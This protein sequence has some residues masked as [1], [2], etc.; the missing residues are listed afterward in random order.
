MYF[1]IFNQT[2]NGIS[3]HNIRNMFQTLSNNRLHALEPVIGNN[4]MLIATILVETSWILRLHS[5]L[6]N[7]VYIYMYARNTMYV[8][9]V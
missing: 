2:I 1:C 9:C 4:Y 6:Y 3:F 7:A 8:M 5:L